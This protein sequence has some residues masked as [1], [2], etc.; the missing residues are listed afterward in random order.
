MALAI[1]SCF[2][3]F[4]TASAQNSAGRYDADC[5]IHGICRRA[6]ALD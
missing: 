3:I 5:G 1:S 2:A 4:V 6:S